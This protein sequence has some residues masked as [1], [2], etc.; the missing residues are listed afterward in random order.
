ML[1]LAN[2]ATLRNAIRKA[3]TVKPRVRVNRFGSYAVTN[4]ATGATYVVTCEKR[5][6]KRYG[7]C[8]CVAGEQGIPCYHLA[9][10]VGAHITLAA[11]RPHPNH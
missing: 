3:R 4:K 6:G 8:T 9:A 7:H 2:A 1:L 11:E 10:A 5:D